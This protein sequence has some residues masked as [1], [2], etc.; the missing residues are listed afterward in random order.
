MKKQLVSILLASAVISSPVYGESLAAALKPGCVMK[1][2]VSVNI[3]FNQKTPSFKEAKAKFDEQMKSIE[4]YAKQQELKKFDKQS[5]NYNIY[6]QMDNNSPAYQLSGN[7][8]YQLDNADEAFKFAEF[9]TAQKFQVNLNS[10]A[11]KQG[12]CN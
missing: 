12:N 1:E 3:S 6:S 2:T 7:V 11:Y 10:N 4:Q 5:M 8:Q 9:L